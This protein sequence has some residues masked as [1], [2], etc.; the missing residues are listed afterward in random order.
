MYKI[1]PVEIGPDG[2]KKPILNDWATK[3]SNDPE[4]IKQWQEFYGKRIV[5]WGLPTGKI[6]GIWA[7]DIDCKDGVSGYET[8]KSMG[9]SEL[10]QTSWQQSPS[11]GM[12]LFFKADNPSVKYPTSVNRELKLDTRGDGGFVWYYSPNFNI[13]IIDAPD[14]VWNITNKRPKDST[15]AP[16]TGNIIQLDPQIAMTTFNNSIEAILNAGQ[17][18][19]NH[20]LNTHAYV[21]GKLV[22]NGAVSHQYAYEKLTEAALKIG[23]EKRETHI[24][25]MSGLGSGEQKP[26]TIDF[27]NPTPNIALPEAPKITPRDRWT[28]KFGTAQML[29]DW[30]KLKKPQLFKDWST[31]DIHL[32]SAIGGVGKTTIKLFEAICLALGEPF[33]GFEC[34]QAGRTLFIIGEDSEEKLYASLGWMCK[35][36]GFMEAGQEHK[37]NAILN[38]IVIKR[39]TDLCLVSQD[40]RTKNF[41]PNFDDL[42]KVKMAIVT[43]KQI[44]RA[45]V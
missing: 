6:N 33:L 21:I 10:P 8:L 9:I 31:E 15:P 45:H 43:G 37:I 2:R 36:L 28:P 34:L 42:T 18:E 27:G 19:R 29:T 13:P 14:W 41:I 1:F 4:I 38:N 20:T 17:G 12:H 22:A 32:T 26:T 3:S 39:A 23:L 25:I 24:T 35:Q 40:P 5:G 30:S 44:G 11:G 7:L 16:V